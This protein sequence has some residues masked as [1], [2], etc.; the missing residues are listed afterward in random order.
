MYPTWVARHLV[1]WARERVEMSVPLMMI[2]PVVGESMPAM[3]LRRVVLPEPDGP[4]SERNSP[5]G[6]S[7]D[8]FSSGLMVVL[9]LVKAL[10]TDLMV[11]RLSFIC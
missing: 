1:S 5:R 6:T 7:R 8:K 3:R 11:M 4:M 2:C 9:P 10:V